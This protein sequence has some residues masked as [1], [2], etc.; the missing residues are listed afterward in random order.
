MRRPLQ[1]GLVLGVTWLLGTTV[2]AQDLDRNLYRTIDGTY[3][4]LQNPE[5]GSAFENLL[6]I[7]NQMGYSDGISA[8]GGINRPNPREISNEIFAQDFMIHDPLKLSDFTWV[9]GQFIDHDIGLTP[10]GQEDASIAVPAGDSYFDPRET[11]SATIAMH[12]NVFDQST[13]TSTDNPRRHPNEI[14]AYIDGSGVYGSDNERAAWLR[15]FVD[16]KLK[17][18]SGNMLPFN[19]VTGEFQ[20]EVDREAPEMDNPVGLIRKQFVAGDVRANENPVL[21]SFHTLFVREHNLV[22][23]ELKA[24]H[25]DWGD[26]ELYLHARKIVIGKLQSIVYNEWLP[27]MGVELPPYSG[28]DSRAHAQLFNAFTA[29]AFRVGHTLLNANLQRVMND[30]S[31]HPEGPLPLRRAFFNPLAVMEDGGIDPFIKGMAV[32]VQ[33]SFDQRVVND[34]R[35]FLFGPPGSPGLD[36]A[37]IN[38]NRGRERGLSDFNS[39][40]V[41]LGLEPYQLFREINSDQRVSGR[42]LGLYRDVEEIDPWVGMLAEDKASDGDLF[43]ETIKQFMIVQ[44][45]LLRDGDR[46][47][48]ENDPVLSQ[49]EKELIRNTTMHDI[50]MRNTDIKLMQ[51]NVFEAMPHNEICDNMVVDLSGRIW[52]EEGNPVSDVVIDL[53]LSNGTM[54]SVSS[55]EGNFELSSIPGCFAKKMTATKGKKDYQNGVT[56]FDMVL[57]QKHILRRS[58]LT[59]PYKILAAD[60]DL[61]GS[62]TTLD[63][64]KMR[65]VIL[66]VATDFGGAPAWRFIPADHVFSDPTDP[67]TDNVTSE[68][69]FDLLSKDSERNYIA[70]KLGDLNGSAL[71]TPA[72]QQAET[73]SFAG[74]LTLLA[75]DQSFTQGNEIAVTLTPEQ[76][77]VWTGWQFGLT[78]NPQ[79]LEYLR[80]ESS[81]LADWSDSNVGVVADEGRL[82]FSWHDPSTRGV[83]MTAEEPVV[84]LFFKA[85]QSGSLSAYMNFQA[86]NLQPESYRPDDEPKPLQVLFSGEQAPM[87]GTF[88]VEQNEPNPFAQNTTIRYFIPEAGQVTLTV[89]DA[90][91]RIV[92]QQQQTVSPGEHQFQLEPGTTM[93][94]AGIYQ[95]QVQIGEQSVTRQM[96]R[97]TKE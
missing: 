81:Q 27:A 43:G 32:Q 78:Y 88:R 72:A 6:L 58:P 50:I 92:L 9:F 12:R 48:Y 74:G 16:G 4:N 23:D 14:T 47:F 26:E 70:I 97:V 2:L 76:A 53:L 18:S 93:E 69:E 3:N 36:L 11:G 66:S 7:T 89:S 86:A 71:T 85:R 54:Q 39:I 17:V 33:Q 90:Q 22:C 96:I 28:Y 34:V 25:P 13:G 51:S 83:T 79:V 37:S 55:E 67:F 35:N 65:R 42:L 59:S 45:G 46:F 49:S 8:P 82:L 95:Y 19:T 40:R 31:V 44:F 61:S 56:T 5:W 91:G 20:D 60:V 94:A 87:T 52:T 68:L 63:L 41:A 77:A 21:L 30:G 15:S 1:F 38:I 80:A 64:I 24:E 75:D 84:T 73:R 57:V 10:D 62:I 29:A